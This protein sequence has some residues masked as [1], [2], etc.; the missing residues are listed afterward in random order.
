MA[1]LSSENP[2]HEPDYTANSPFRRPPTIEQLLET[3]RRRI[4]VCDTELDE[5]RRRRDIIGAALLREFRGSRVYVNGSVAHGDALNPLTDI[6]LGIVVA[7]AKHTHGPGKKGCSDLQE[8]AA[9]AIRAALREE[10]PGL[11]LEWRGR[12]RS[13]LVRFSKP[14]TYGQDDFTADVI[15]AIDNPDDE[16]LFIPNYQGWSRSHPEEHTRLVREANKATGYTYARVVRLIKHYNRRNQKPL[17]SWNIKA[18]ALGA[19]TSRSRLTDGIL[20]WFDH[21]IVS[22]SKGLTE[23][24]AHVAEQ[25]IAINDKMT[26]TEVVDRLTK[27]RERLVNALDLEKAGYP[28]LAHE[29]LAKLFNDEDML[30]YPDTDAVRREA[31]RKYI[32]DR[33]T[34]TSGGS[35]HGSTGSTADSAASAA[36]VA[37]PV[38]GLHRGQSA[39]NSRSWGE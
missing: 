36:A 3:A 18:L 12:R 39:S 38:V 1:I 34:P 14:V 6:D 11:R 19:L 13:I 30:P 24:P 22:L 17:C 29:Q 4:Q 26:R 27:S 33:R 9:N 10:F 28:V 23:D 16:G 8:R 20:A 25:P 35:N 7:E 31:A 15:I 2:D 21:A 32:N 5:A 37:A